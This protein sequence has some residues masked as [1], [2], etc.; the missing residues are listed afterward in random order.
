MMNHVLARLLAAALI[1]SSL[2]ACG[3]RN[4]PVAPSAAQKQTTTQ[5]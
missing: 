3:V 1:L 2:S 5:N 4:D